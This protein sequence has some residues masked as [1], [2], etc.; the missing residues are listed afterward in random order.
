MRFTFVTSVTFGRRTGVG[1]LRAA[2][3]WLG[4]EVVTRLWVRGL[5]DSIGDFGNEGVVFDER[6][7]G[8]RFGSADAEPDESQ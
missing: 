4:F 5:G 7:I 8:E 3:L 2:R 1:D 6:V